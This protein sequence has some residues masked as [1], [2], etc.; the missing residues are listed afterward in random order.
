MA[1]I[2]VGV[3]LKADGSGMV[4]EV[5]MSKKELD[6]LTGATKSG[7][8]AANKASRDYDKMGREMR[9]TTHDVKRLNDSQKNLNRTLLATA[10]TYFSLRTASN[11][12]DQFRTQEQAVAA[13]DASIASMGRTTEGLSGNLQT[14]ASQ[15]QANGII[16]D[17]ALIKGQSFL[18][19]FGNITDDLLPRTSRIMADIAA[20]M[21]GDTV[22]AA[23]LLG[24]A[25]MGM[26]GELSRMG[27]TLS[28]TAKES[29]DFELILSEIE[30][31]V[32]GMNQA[33]ANTATGGLDQFKNA[34]GDTQEEAGGLLAEIF[35][36]E[37]QP[38]LNLLNEQGQ[39][40]LKFFREFYVDMAE[41]RSRAEQRIVKDFLAS[42]GIFPEQEPLKIEITGGRESDW[43]NIDLTKNEISQLNEMF[44]EGE[45]LTQAMLTPLE[46]YEA[47]I[48]RI[49]ELWQ[50]GMIS[51]ETYSRAVA[52][53]QESFV[54]QSEES[55]LRWSD[56]WS[57]AGN[58]FA[59]GIGD[60]VAEAVFEQQSLS[61]TM[62][63]VLRGILKQILSTLVEIGVKKA[64][65]AVMGKTALATQTAASVAAAGITAAAWAPAAAATSLASFGTNAAPA[66]AGISSTYGLA[67]SLSLLGVAHD[68][69]FNVPTDGTYL[70]QG[71]EMVVNKGN[72][73]KIRG[74]AEG[75]K[76]GPIIVN[77]RF[78]LSAVDARGID[79]LLMQR[80]G[81][82]KSW[83]VEAA[84]EYAHSHGRR[85]LV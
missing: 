67:Q 39:A 63:T 20:K 34:L 85:G 40:V 41:E 9:D 70:L 30:Q 69:L 81:L 23:N 29:K 27:I 68:G 54:A 24:K 45:R 83:A 64:A 7:G 25:S 46:Q 31:Q 57:S 71:G 5:R 79:S 55:A 12:V 11:L 66:S 8:K 43:A 76:A 74:A 47:A 17:E 73:E 53:S 78:I 59:A 37:F 19:T 38:S 36:Y 1:E 52:A 44:K 49:N 16:G 33:L 4:G 35:R 51:N 65:L 84:Q 75:G 3:R 62:R 2:V 60:A 15:I 48:M 61:E 58:R 26:T 72:A 21:G 80:R 18:T 13:L 56:A 32:G 50:H 22:S 14:L 82:F 42:I 28:D 77:Q 6:K 10:T